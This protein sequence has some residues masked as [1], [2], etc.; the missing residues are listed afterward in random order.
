MDAR[1]LGSLVG[2]PP[3][4]LAALRLISGTFLRQDFKTV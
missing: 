2:G 4:L 3:L 1:G